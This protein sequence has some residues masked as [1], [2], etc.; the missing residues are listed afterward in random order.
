MS[1][2]LYILC[3]LSKYIFSI[4]CKYIW[5]NLC[6][7]ILSFY[8]NIYLFYIFYL[9]M[10]LNSLEVEDPQENE[11]EE[12]TYFVDQAGHYYYQAKGDSQPVM[13]MV[14]G[15]AEAAGEE[16]E[17][18]IINQ[19]NDEDAAEEEAEEVTYLCH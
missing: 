3:I 15:L 9:N 14:P 2:E 6:K 17:E 12:G 13:T 1:P 16:G 18:F 11:E 7:F 5:S 4:L 10:F 8:V 19:E